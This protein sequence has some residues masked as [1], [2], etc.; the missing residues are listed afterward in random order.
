[1]NPEEKRSWD[2]F[3]Q[4]EN[5]W[6]NDCPKI[7][8]D[9]FWLDDQLIF[10]EFD[11][12]ETPTPINEPIRIPTQP[13]VKLDQ[14]KIGE[15]LAVRGSKQDD[16]SGDKFW[17]GKVK[18]IHKHTKTIRLAYYSHT[19]ADTYIQDP[20]RS[21]GSAPLDSILFANINL[22]KK[23]KIPFYI[24]KHLHRLLIRG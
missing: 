9:D 15:L 12:D 17:I 2:T 4:D 11:E 1:M 22:T 8:L 20:N 3:L 24:Q 13:N 18:K 16:Q 7:N 19:K 14:I 10:Q 23:K 6:F 5:T 21:T